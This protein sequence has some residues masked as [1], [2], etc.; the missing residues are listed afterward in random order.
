MEQNRHALLKSISEFEFVCVELNEYLDTHPADKKAR[1]DYVCYSKK[2]ASLIKEYETAYG[3]LKNFGHSPTE[4]GCW[5]CS[6]WPW[7]L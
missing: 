5:I 4:A 7:E 6:K 3:P 1:A 2:L